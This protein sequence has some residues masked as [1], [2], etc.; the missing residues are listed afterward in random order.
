MHQTATCAGW[1]IAKIFGGKNKVVVDVGGL[2]MNGSL[3]QYF[4]EAGMKHICIDI[5]AH[6]S[7]DIVIKPADKLP[8]ETGSVDLIVSTSCFEHDPCFWLTFKEMTR[9]LKPD[10]YIYIN[11]PTYGVYHRAPGDNWRFYSDAGQALAYWSGIQVSNEEVYPVKVIETFHILPNNDIWTDFVCV[12]QRT[13]EKETSITISPEIRN[14]YGALEQ[15][16][17]M[18]GF[19]TTKDINSHKQ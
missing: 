8:F 14:R 11:A 9:I 5:E 16:I 1:A 15:S 19:K 3:R 6:P 4:E 7:V 13:N 2:N 17:N 10:G 18:N 12:W